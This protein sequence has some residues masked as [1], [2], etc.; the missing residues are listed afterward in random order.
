MNHE[1]EQQVTVA[2][3]FWVKGLSK[4]KRYVPKNGEE[5]PKMIHQQDVFVHS[6]RTMFLAECLMAALKQNQLWSREPNRKH[7][8]DMAYHHDDVEIVTDDMIASE[9][10]W[11]SKEK[12]Q[13]SE[14]EEDLAFY[15][16]AHFI[17]GLKPPSDQL[18]VNR[19]REQKKKITLESQI[20]DV[21]DKWDAVC[22]ILH[23]IRCGNKPFA[24][25]LTLSKLNF[26]S[27]VVKYPFFRA[28]EKDPRFEFDKIPTPEQAI[29][30][31]TINITDLKEISDTAKLM[32]LEKTKGWPTCYRTWAEL[33]NAI[34]YK[35]GPEKFIFPGWYMQLWSKW[36][37]FPGKTTASGLRI[38]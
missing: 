5:F 36:N 24:K 10:V 31:S 29:E 7:L 38:R 14:Q 2:E 21:A 4:V 16:V 30:L 37:Y 9:K 32:S 27:F 3:K 33:N 13:K 12:L 34:F 28:I 15:A 8:L 6:R 18:Y 25:L 20:V 17:F 22:E 19:Q 26:N 11:L 1:Q 23:E 35:E